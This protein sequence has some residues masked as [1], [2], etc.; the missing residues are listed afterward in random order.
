[1][2]RPKGRCHGGMP[3]WGLSEWGLAE[4]ESLVRSKVVIH[5]ASNGG[6]YHHIHWLFQTLALPLLPSRVGE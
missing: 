6:N 1:M 2:V 4:R 5:L 3:Q